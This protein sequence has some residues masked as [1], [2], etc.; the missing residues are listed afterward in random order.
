MK[1]YAVLSLG[2]GLRGVASRAIGAV[3]LTFGPPP[4]PHEGDKQACPASLTGRTASWILGN[5][6]ASGSRI[7]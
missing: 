3:L 1:A 2:F 5:G 4:L 6:H 7:D